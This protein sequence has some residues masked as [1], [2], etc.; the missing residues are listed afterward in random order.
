[1]AR[2]IAY[3]TSTVIVAVMLL[4]ALSYLTGNPQVVSGFAKGWRWRA[5]VG[6]A[7]GAAGPTHRLLFLQAFEPPYGAFAVACLTEGNRTIWSLF[8]CTSTCLV[9]H[10]AAATVAPD[11]KGLH[12]SLRG[13]E[14]QEPLGLSKCGR[15][16][17]P[18]DR[19]S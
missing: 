12:P 4:F 9:L 10:A 7:A 5:S 11:R 8:I 16:P 15:M 18:T 17:A 14:R 19:A 13:R 2:K 1:M 3:W 6:H